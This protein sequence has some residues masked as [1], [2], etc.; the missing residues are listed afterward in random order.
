MNRQKLIRAAIFL[1]GF[2]FV[3]GAFTFVLAFFT[4]G[5]PNPN[6]FVNTQATVVQY[7]NGKEI[8]R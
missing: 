6:D 4:V 1:V 7:S 3:I 8:G 2:G 5:I